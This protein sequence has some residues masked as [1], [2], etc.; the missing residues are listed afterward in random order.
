MAKKK[1]DQAAEIEAEVAEEMERNPV[2]GMAHKVLLAGIGAVALTQEEVEKFV[3]KLVERGEI[4]EQDGKKLVGDVMEKRKQEA[5][6]AEGELDKRLEDLLD[7]MN[8]PTKTDIDALSAK[9]TELS[10]KVDELKEG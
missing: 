4:A 8:V 6:K 3:G 9:I 5:K 10:K 2:L 1:E 7:R